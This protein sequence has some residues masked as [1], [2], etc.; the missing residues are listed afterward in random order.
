MA[1][2]MI[3]DTASSTVTKSAHTHIQ[4]YRL[5][6]THR[7]RQTYTGTDRQTDRQTD[8]HTHTHTH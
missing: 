7:H 8:T 3:M 4:A 2:G 1:T 6:G 5:T